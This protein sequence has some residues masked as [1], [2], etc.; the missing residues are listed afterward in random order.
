MAEP[1][2]GQLTMPQQAVKQS[3]KAAPAGEQITYLPGPEDSPMVKWGGHTFHANL[4]KMVN[5]TALVER[6]RGNRF[7]KVG[8]FVASDA[9]ATRDEPVSPK[10]PEQY[11][12]HAIGWLKT[13]TSV[14]ELD[15]KWAGEET[16]RMACG[17][18]S[19]DLEY[20]SELF[21]PIR[22][23]LRKRDMAS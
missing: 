18:G 9:V 3:E 21:A 14:D 23:D 6:A 8:A 4:P 20:L 5:D 13:M 16:L 17:V 7:F 11:R 15:R 19:D 22:S 10:T 2:R 1:T 12:A